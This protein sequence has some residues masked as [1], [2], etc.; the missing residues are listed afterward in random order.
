MN[1][2]KASN[3]RP[4]KI[5]RTVYFGAGVVALVMGIIGIFVPIWPTTC[6][7]LMA[8]GCFSKSS[9]R[10]HDWMLHNRWFGRHLRDYRESGIVDRRILA[11]SLLSLWLSMGLSLSLITPPLWVC[12][13]ILSVGLAVTMHLVQVGVQSRRA[14]L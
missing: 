1:K 13:I 8:I 3:R 5:R 14:G 11:G 2:N 7:L 12:L 10:A 6:F 9:Q 4:D